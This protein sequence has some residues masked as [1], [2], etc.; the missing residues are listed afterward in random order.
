[1]ATDYVIIYFEDYMDNNTSRLQ[2]MEYFFVGKFRSSGS[3]GAKEM[4]SCKLQ[5]GLDHAK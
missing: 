4:R 2:R 5:Q 1:M 3:S